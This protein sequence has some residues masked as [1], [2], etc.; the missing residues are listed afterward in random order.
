MFV[1]DLTIDVKSRREIEQGVLKSQDV[2]KNKKLQ[3]RESEVS[4]IIKSFSDWPKLYS[5]LKL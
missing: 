1:A 5:G 2:G 3:K 4:K